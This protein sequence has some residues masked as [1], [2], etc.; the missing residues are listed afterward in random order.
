M[1]LLKKAN[2]TLWIYILNLCNIVSDN[3]AY[4]IMMTTILFVGIMYIIR[5]KIF[6]SNSIFFLP[7]FTYILSVSY[8]VERLPLIHTR[9]HKALSTIAGILLQSEDYMHGFVTVSK[10]DNPNSKKIAQYLYYSHADIFT[11][12]YP[13]ELYE[14]LFETLNDIRRIFFIFGN[15]HEAT[16]I[17][18]VL[19]FVILICIIQLCQ[20]NTYK[21]FIILSLQVLFLIYISTVNNGAV[22]AAIILYSMQLL[23][24]GMQQ[25]ST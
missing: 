17:Y 5:R 3:V 24:L 20:K 7:E 15:V 2:D 14:H 22:L 10:L 23:I 4:S 9:I 18:P 1:E 6:K 21:D 12:T 19:G 11:N 8:M 16:W 25:N 13:N